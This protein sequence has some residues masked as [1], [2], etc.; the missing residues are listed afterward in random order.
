MADNKTK[1]TG[2]SV[3]DYLEGITPDQKRAD[4]FHLMEMMARASGNAPCM[5]GDSMVGYGTYHYK[6]DS[7]REGDYFIT[8]FA[9]RKKNLVVYIMPGFSDYADL[10]ARL[11]KHKTSSSCLYINKLSDIDMDVLEEI[12]CQSIEL[13]KIKY[14]DNDSR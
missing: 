14:R 6:Y 10:L 9:P 7:G 4:S 5:W 8:G 11:G 2:A 1:P 12:V 13:M 3:D